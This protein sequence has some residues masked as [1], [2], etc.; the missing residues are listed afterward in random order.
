MPL[1]TP[2]TNRVLA[3]DDLPPQF[4]PGN[5]ARLE[6][7]EATNFSPVQDMLPGMGEVRSGSP[8]ST[9]LAPEEEADFKRAV[10]G[11][12]RQA[13]GADNVLKKLQARIQTLTAQ[14]QAA[15]QQGIE[16]KAANLRRELKALLKK[17]EYVA[18]RGQIARNATKKAMQP[19]W[20]RA[21]ALRTMRPQQAIKHMQSPATPS[22]LDY[23]PVG[24]SAQ[25]NRAKILA[26]Q[27]NI[28]PVQQMS[29]IW[30]DEL[31]PGVPN[32]TIAAASGGLILL[33]VLK[34]KR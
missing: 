13:N 6:P 23:E 11:A 28:Q 7:S 3:T 27:A 18:Q 9:G 12:K 5:Q 10:N 14:I 15:D 17:A 21:S 26:M 31:I 30:T 4:R 24:F 2:T 33:M 8:M 25:K 32:W 1:F 16:N 20:M 22:A 34:K 29:G 19:Y